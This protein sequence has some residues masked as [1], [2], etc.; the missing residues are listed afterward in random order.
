MAE[1]GHWQRGSVGG[2]GETASA[3]VRVGDEQQQSTSSADLQEKFGELRNRL[4]HF[5][6]EISVGESFALV[7]TGARARKEG[8][9]YEACRCFSEGGE[10]MAKAAE[11]EADAKVKDLYVHQN[12]NGKIDWT[13]RETRNLEEH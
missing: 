3:V 12:Y 5:K 8:R 7:E 9:Y 11:L 1:E 4:S 13:K 2:E 6:K 10:M